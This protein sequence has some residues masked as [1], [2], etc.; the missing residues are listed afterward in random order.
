MKYVVTWRERAA[1]SAQGYEQTQ[2]RVLDIFSAW[3][4]PDTL[5][6]HQFLVRVGEFGGTPSSKQMTRRLS[7]G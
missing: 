1:G 2:Q 6:I 4:M 3:E 5:N 7:T